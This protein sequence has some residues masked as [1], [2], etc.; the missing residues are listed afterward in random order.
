MSANSAVGDEYNRGMRQCLANVGLAVLVGGCSLIYN[1]DNLPKERA[2]AFVADAAIDANPAA[3]SVDAVLPTKIDEGQGDFG[4]RPQILVVHGSNFVTGATVAITASQPIMIDVDNA[5]L[6]VATESDLIAVPITAHVA[7]VGEG[8]QIAL[9]VQ[10]S[11]PAAGG[12]VMQQLSGAL[13]LVGHDKLVAA[14]AGMPHAVYSQIAITGSI[15]VN[16]GTLTMPYALRAIS[17]IDVGTITANGG[18][19]SGGTGGAAGPNGCAG[20]ASEADAGCVPCGG[21]KGATPS[22]TGTGGDGGGA[23]FATAGMPG[24]GGSGPGAGG[25]MCGDD[26]IASYATNQAAGGGGG[27]ANGVS[28]GSGAGGGGGGGAVELTAGGN[29]TVAQVNA[30]GGAGGSKPAGGGAG[31][32]GAGG[33]VMVRAG[34]TLTVMTGLSATGGDGDGTSTTDGKAS[35]GRIRWDAPAGSAPSATPTA[36]RGPAFVTMPEV[37]TSA[38]LQLVGSANHK[39]DVYWIDSA[40]Q[41]NDASEAG[42]SFDVSGMA[43]IHPPLGRGYDHVCITLAG[44]AQGA[45]EAD[46]CVDVAYMP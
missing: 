15:T 36:V 5:H 39:F 19:A 29:V 20:A 6:V 44:G 31:G 2:D 27:G 10:V 21:H 37:I 43:T 3:L 42:S 18:A 33:V 38:A 41:H 9:T 7:G 17:S 16:P 32:G 8:T 12:T 14:P 11:Q 35:D 1:A 24:T 26:M 23:G 13:M 30:N 4:S 25:Q 28:I 34:G 46:K 40:G 45:I 22:V